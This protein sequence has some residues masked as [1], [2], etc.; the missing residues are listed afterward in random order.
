MEFKEGQRII[1]V[2]RGVHFAD[3][4]GNIEDANFF[5]Y[6]IGW[7]GTVVNEGGCGESNVINFDNGRIIH[8][9]FDGSFEELKEAKI[10][11]FNKGDKVKV[12]NCTGYNQRFNGQTGEYLEKVED[13]SVAMHRVCFDGTGKSCGCVFKDSE[14][15]LVTQFTIGSKVTVKHLSD[16]KQFIDGKMITRGNVVYE[17]CGLDFAEYIITEIL[18]SKSFIRRIS[19]GVV[20]FVSPEFLKEYITKPKFKRGDFVITGNLKCN[21][22]SRVFKVYPMANGSYT[23]GITGFPDTYEHSDGNVIIMESELSEAII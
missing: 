15:E 8:G 14:L 7:Q 20:F 6:N 22:Y 18:D 19:D 13:L 10:T 23:Y 9:V 5:D 12:S 21:A 2:E 16:A 4:Q 11:M 3:G 17:E 1:A